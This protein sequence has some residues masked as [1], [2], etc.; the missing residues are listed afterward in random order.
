M[1]SGK[2]F[3]CTLKPVDL[4]TNQAHKDKV[5]GTHL[6]PIYLS[7]WEQIYNLD[8]GLEIQYNPVVPYVQII[9][10]NY[11]KFIVICIAHI[12][13][14]IRAETCAIRKLV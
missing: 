13:R 3:G 6:G 8:L 9:I 14:F 11:Y 10:I 1:N 7:V 5:Y 2:I 12:Y 4:E